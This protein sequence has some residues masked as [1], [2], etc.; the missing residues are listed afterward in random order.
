MLPVPVSGSQAPQGSPWRWIATVLSEFEVPD[1]VKS[2]ALEEVIPS[3]PIPDELYLDPARKL[4]PCHTPAAAWVSA[5]LLTK[6]A[7]EMDSATVQRLTNRAQT[8]LAFWGLPVTLPQPRPPQAKTAQ[9][10]WVSDR[11]TGHALPINTPDE[12]FRAAWW[13][14]A[15]AL[16]LPFE[17]RRDVAQ[18]ILKQAQALNLDPLELPE[19]VAQWAGYG[20]AAPQQVV[21]QLRVRVM[22]PLPDNVAGM[23]KT[24]IAALERLSGAEWNQTVLHKV[25][26]LMAN[27]DAIP[28]HVTYGNLLQ[29]PEQ[30]CYAI[31]AHKLAEAAQEAVP[32]QNGKVVMLSQL[33]EL[34]ETMLKQAFGSEFL[35]W[36]TGPDGQRDPDKLRQEAKSLPADQAD[37]LTDLIRHSTA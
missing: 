6:Q 9:Y 32:L 23:L 30:V 24:A 37:L 36:I 35:T 22:L 25:A 20:F 8:L 1:F 12:V 10:A 26:T 15:N 16:R 29:P 27:V 34:P 28:R 21:N 5:A 7:A 18:R 3:Q 4:Y 33:M 14:D 17:R 11:P 31:T 13:L 2:A 19:S